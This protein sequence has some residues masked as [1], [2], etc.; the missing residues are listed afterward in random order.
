MMMPRTIILTG[1]VLCLTACAGLGLGGKDEMPPEKAESVFKSGAVT[2]TEVDHGPQSRSLLKEYVA[3]KER[4]LALEENHKALQ[5]KLDRA[6]TELETLQKNLAS[7]KVARSGAEAERD[8][9]RGQLRD[10][11]VQLLDLAL[12]K[13]QVEREL[14]TLKIAKLE[15]E[16]AARAAAEAAKKKAAAEEGDA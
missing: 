6:T 1:S 12:Q 14:V 10:L 4:H 11:E 3:L 8:R 5:D 7:E 9:S 13:T 15:A 16:A 2:D